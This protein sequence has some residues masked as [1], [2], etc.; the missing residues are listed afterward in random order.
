MGGRQRPPYEVGREL[1]GGRGEAG[2]PSHHVHALASHRLGGCKYPCRTASC[3]EEDWRIASRLEP[4]TRR[5]EPG[6]RNGSRP[7]STAGKEAS[8]VRSVRDLPDMGAVLLCSLALTL[9]SAIVEAG[10]DFE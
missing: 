7:A 3:T 2:W 1:G 10:T 8:A 6:L 5:S 4:F 9:A